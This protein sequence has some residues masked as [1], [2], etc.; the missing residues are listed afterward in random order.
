VFGT[1]HRPSPRRAPEN[2]LYDH[3]CELVDAAAAIR[4]AAADPASAD[5]VPALL[6]CLEAA[7]RDLVLLADELEQTAAGHADRYHGRAGQ[8]YRNLRVAL[9]DAA[10]TAHI[11]QALAARA[12]SAE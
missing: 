5:A 3:A 7:L 1:S 8:G 9:D 2:E 11:A 12:A 4:R 6:G 10:G